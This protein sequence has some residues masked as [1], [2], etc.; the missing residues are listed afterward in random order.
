MSK[1]EGCAYFFPVSEEHDAESGKGDC[2]VEKKDEKGKFWLGK[3]VFRD[4]E[5]CSNFQTR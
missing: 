2:V 4:M 5:A 1:C 3:E